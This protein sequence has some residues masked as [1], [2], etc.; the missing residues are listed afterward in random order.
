AGYFYTS[1]QVEVTPYLHWLMRR[2]K[3]NGGKV[4][5]AKITNLNQV[6]QDCDL[7]VTCCSLGAR[8]LLQDKEIGP[9]RGQVIRVIAPWVKHFYFYKPKSGMADYSYIL[10]G[11]S[12]IVVGGTAQK[13][14]W[15]T[16]IDDQD[17][18]KIWE[19]AC[20]VMPVLSKAKKVREWAGLRP[21][22]DNV[23]L[24]KEIIQV[25]DKK[26][27]VVHNYGFGGSGITIH[28]GCAL[29]TAKMVLELLGCQASSVNSRL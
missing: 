3:E 26:M 2:F 10:P 14:D 18:T 9:T 27:K 13:G 4:R 11:T 7:I 29:E 23:R 1:V 25:G 8:E 20:Q 15:R 5:K 24:E 16:T 6:A 21:S 19:T 28:W 17:S 22:R 12:E